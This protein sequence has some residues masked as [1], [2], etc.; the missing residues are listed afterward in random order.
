MLPLGLWGVTRP[1][2]NTSWNLSTTQVPA[3]GAIGVDVFGLVDPG[4]DDLSVLGA[5][6]CGLRGV[7]EPATER[8]GRDHVERRRRHD[9]QLM[10]QAARP[11]P[12]FGQ[13]RSRLGP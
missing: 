5:P 7:P 4:I 11:D 1:L 12:R 2:V 10:S 6:D 3:N 9:R 13:P 8:L